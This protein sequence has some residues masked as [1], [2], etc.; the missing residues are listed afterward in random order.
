[1]VLGIDEY[2][3]DDKKDKEVD[4]IQFKK[5]FQRIYKKTGC[6][7]KKWVEEIKSRNE[8]VDK[9]ESWLREELEGL[10]TN[11]YIFGHSYYRQGYFKRINNVT[12]NNNNYLLL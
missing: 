3:N 5:Y 7:Y 8:K 1:M 2:L 11:L 4:F 10:E 6:E 9:K 12:K